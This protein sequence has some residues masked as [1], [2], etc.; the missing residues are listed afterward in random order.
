MKKISN[1]KMCLIEAGVSNR[2]CLILGWGAFAAA[3]TLRAELCLGITFGA[4]ASGCFG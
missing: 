3:V 4:A 1:Q 2:T